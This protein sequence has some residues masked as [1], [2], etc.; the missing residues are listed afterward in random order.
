MW[1][2]C[3]YAD[4][5]E[6]YLAHKRF[7]INIYCI[8]VYTE[9]LCLLCFINLRCPF[10]T[11]THKNSIHSSNAYLKCTSVKLLIPPS[12][13]HCSICCNTIII[14]FSLGLV[15]L[16]IFYYLAFLPLACKLLKVRVCLTL[17]YTML[18]HLLFLTY[19][20]NSPP[21]PAT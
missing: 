7:S 19:H 13:T 12:R 2:L 20:A 18:P 6:Q 8:N 21:L 3:T 17:L 5:L 14:W 16:V 1:V 10:C 15:C 11:A 4:L 9:F